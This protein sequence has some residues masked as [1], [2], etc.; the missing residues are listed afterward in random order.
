[1]H[2]QKQRLAQSRKSIQEEAL[3]QANQTEAAVAGG[4]E[5]GSSLEFHDLSKFGGSIRMHELQDAHLQSYKTRADQH[6]DKYYLAARQHSLH[7]ST[8]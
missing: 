1:M 3:S 6:Q 4:S 2:L 8:N 7:G 5:A